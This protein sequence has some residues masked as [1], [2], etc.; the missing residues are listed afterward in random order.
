MDMRP[1]KYRVVVEVLEVEGLSEKGFVLPD[2]VVEWIPP[3]QGRVVA[4]GGGVE[5]TAV[6]SK[7]LYGLGAGM[8]W[9]GLLV[10]HENDII[11]EMD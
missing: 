7:V 9:N 4:I 11:C 2:T 1:T 8:E 10:L 6:G 3:T 5:K